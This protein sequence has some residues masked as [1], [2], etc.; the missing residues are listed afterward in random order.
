MM[1]VMPRMT[2]MLVMVMVVSAAGAVDMTLGRVL[3]L[4]QLGTGA[5]HAGILIG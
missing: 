5:G 2:A 3:L 1:V 4:Q